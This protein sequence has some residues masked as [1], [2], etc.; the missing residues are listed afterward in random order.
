MG[1]CFGC[2]KITDY[3]DSHICSSKIYN[4]STIS[5]DPIDR[6]SNWLLAKERS[7]VYDFIC[8]IVLIGEQVK[9]FCV[10]HWG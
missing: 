7:F 9:V 5:S 8:K 1:N 6:I 3:E 4:Y 2:G 10:Q